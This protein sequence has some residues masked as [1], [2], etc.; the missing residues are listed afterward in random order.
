LTQND[1]RGK[2][3]VI[4]VL[5]SNEATAQHLARILNEPSAAG[6][7][8]LPFIPKPEIEALLPDNRAARRGHK[9]AVADHKY[10]DLKR[11]RK[12]RRI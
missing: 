12:I 2:D 11:V 8:P 9:K 7:T 1:S 10:N 3:N 6:V 5:V 4:I